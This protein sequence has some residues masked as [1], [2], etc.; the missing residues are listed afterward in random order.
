MLFTSSSKG[1]PFSMETVLPLSSAK[2][3][4]SGTLPSDGAMSEDLTASTMP[5]WA[6]GLENSTCSS[7]SGVTFISVEKSYF[8]ACT[9]G[10]RPAKSMSPSSSR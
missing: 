4:Y 3:R 6:V 1:A 5:P 8:P 9:A 7:R 10:I 2:E